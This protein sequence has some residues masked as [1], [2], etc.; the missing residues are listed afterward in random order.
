MSTTGDNLSG[1]GERA[2]AAT[3]GKPGDGTPPNYS[4]MADA[5]A[6]S[7]VEAAMARVRAVVPSAKGAPITPSSG[8]QRA[9]DAYVFPED[10]Y[11]NLHQARTVAG[12]L[13]V[14]YQL[15]WRTPI[16]GPVWMRVR[17]R[18][19]QEIRIYID[20]LTT[21]QNGLNTYL[22]RSLSQIVDSL[23][24]LGLKVLKRQQSD[25]AEVI[26]ALQAEVKSLR[27]RVEALEGRK[28]GE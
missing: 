11:R 18:I 27:A 25:Q 16:L 15:G 3:N 22:I 14:D 20:A 23:D 12:H 7:R 8:R 28:S 6:V 2:A 10:L 17:Q 5:E 4:A 24:S 1:D 19:H 13:A 26:L 9:G 21:H